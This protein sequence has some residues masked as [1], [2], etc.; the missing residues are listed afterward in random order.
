MDALGQSTTTRI[1]SHIWFRLTR[2]QATKNVSMTLCGGPVRDVTLSVTLVGLIGG[3]VAFLAI[4]LRICSFF[5]AKGRTIGWDDYTIG[6][7][8]M[9]SVPTVVFAPLCTR[10]PMTEGAQPS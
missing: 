2:L 9:I 4:M 7:T 3:G 6:L 1:A 5:G 10:F 8:W